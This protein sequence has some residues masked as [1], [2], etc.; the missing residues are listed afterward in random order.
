MSMLHPYRQDA[1]TRL[2]L[3]LGAQASCWGGGID[4]HKLGHGESHL[5]FLRS[6]G[7]T[8]SSRCHNTRHSL[9]HVVLNAWRPTVNSWDSTIGN[10]T[11]QGP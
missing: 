10:S 9:L 1:K 3:S 4:R 2:E 7:K 5:S 6:R 11:A 8:V